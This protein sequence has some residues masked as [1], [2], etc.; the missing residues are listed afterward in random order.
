LPTVASPQVVTV[1][2]NQVGKL[3]GESSWSAPEVVGGDA[4]ERVLG[5]EGTEKVVEVDEDI[6]FA[7]RLLSKPFSEGVIE[8]LVLRTTLT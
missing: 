5:E 6:H 1:V 7:R 2:A 3:G 4:G 8:N